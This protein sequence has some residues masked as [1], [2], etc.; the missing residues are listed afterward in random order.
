MAAAELVVG[1]Q[2]PTLAA[3]GLLVGAFPLLI[4]AIYHARLYAEMTLMCLPV[5]LHEVAPLMPGS[6]ETTAVS[7]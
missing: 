4:I 7:S 6:T 2:S 3:G 1:V 5:R